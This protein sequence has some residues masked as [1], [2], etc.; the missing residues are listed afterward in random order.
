M[1]TR[2]LGALLLLGALW[3]ASFMFIKIGVEE[4]APEV[5][6]AV[7]LT[8]AAVLLLAVLYGTGQRL[9]SGWRVWRDFAF[10]G[11]VGLVLPFMLITW[12]EQHISSGMTAILNATVPL[13]SALIAYVWMRSEHLSGTK[14]LGVGLGFVGVVLAVGITNLSL[15]SADTQ[16]QLAV[17]VAAVCYGINGV[18][19][20]KAFHG[21]PALVPATGQLTSGALMLAPVALLLHGVPRSL[22]SAQAVGSVLALAVVGTAFAYILLYWLIDQ[23]GATRSSMVTYLTAPFALVYGALFLREEITLNAVL[24]LG[25][26]V[27]GILFANGVFRARSA[28]TVATEQARS[29]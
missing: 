8:I 1:K 26:V 7:R 5:L 19:A 16:S 28:T 3:G 14:L 6:V 4:M 27:V 25:L 18:Y 10:C 12:G 17:L 13:F 24:G 29:S 20:R 22:P 15:H 23:I 9:P 11:L 2:Y 21:M